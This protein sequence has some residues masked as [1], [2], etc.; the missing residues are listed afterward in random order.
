MVKDERSAATARD[1]AAA[2]T[3][4]EDARRQERAAALSL[5]SNVLL[6]AVKVAAGLLSGSI[7]VL[8][9]GVQSTID[10]AASALILL[11]VR[12]AAS[13][14]DRLHPYGHGKFENA[15]SLA[16]MLLILGTAGGILWAAW[17]RWQAPVMP[18][19]D[20]GVA[21]LM[22]SIA[23]NALVSRRLARVARETR[24]SA[25][26]AEAAH[27]RADLLA[28]LGVVLGLLAV[29]ATREP[30]L[31]PAVAAVMTVVVVVGAARLLRETLRPLLDESLPVAEQRAIEDVLDADPRVRAYHR[32]RT[33][34]SGARRHVDVHVQM[35]DDLSFRAAHE[36]A[37]EIEDALRAALPDTDAI[38]HAEPYEAETD[39]QREYHTE[40]AAQPPSVDRDQA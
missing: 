3:A 11:T 17:Q 22:L 12:A 18:R 39:H 38:V 10:I 34:R 2:R 21:A 15:A 4:S 16:Q 30:R 26:A 35:D 33:R 40:R 7:S 29:W 8:A 36:L 20:W 23:V 32:L 6:V 28:C 25:L 27:L 9:E 5:A 24:S 19:V 13:P 31:D 14:P 1:G 37:E